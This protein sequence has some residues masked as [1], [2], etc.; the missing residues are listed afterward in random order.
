MMIVVALPFR[1]ALPIL[2]S[3]KSA[4]EPSGLV[5]ALL[6]R[7]DKPLGR[8]SRRTLVGRDGADGEESEVNGDVV[9]GA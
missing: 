4:L 3:R 5:T 1:E 8:P 2:T 9:M 6:I 7:D